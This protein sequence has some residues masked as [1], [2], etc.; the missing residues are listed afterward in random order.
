MTQALPWLTLFAAGI[1]VA[2]GLGL[3]PAALLFVAKPLATGLIIAWAWP[4]GRAVP[5]QRRL[6]LIG[7][8]LSFAGDVFLL[9]P[10]QGFLPGLVA[11]LLA[12]LTYIAA[13]STSLRFAARPMPFV[14]YAVVAGAILSLLWPGVPP[15][16]RVPVVAYVLCLA[17]M[18]AQAAG[19]GLA[20]RGSADASRGRL[21]AIGGA[22]FMASDALLATNR[23]AVPLP[24]ATL[25]ILSTYWL[26]QWCIAS[27][28]ARK[29]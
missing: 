14:V 11:F 3:L 18:A 27:S 22:L 19:V 23:F 10:K 8:L 4:R 13:F 16:L 24:L 6:V 5:R 7:L 1:A 2:A 26:A 9:W 28:L 12:H 29:T 17:S 21:A 15:G 25:W 20:A